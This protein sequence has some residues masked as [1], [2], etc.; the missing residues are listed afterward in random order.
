VLVAEDDDHLRGTL[1][2]G[3]AE[4][5]YVVE[6]FPRG[7]DALRAGLVGNFDAVTRGSLGVSS[8]LRQMSFPNDQEGRSAVILKPHGEATD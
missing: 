5:G 3:L 7:D 2:R 6:T 1:S 8:R 4:A